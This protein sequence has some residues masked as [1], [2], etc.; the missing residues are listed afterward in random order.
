MAGGARVTRT[1]PSLKGARPLFKGHY[2]PRRPLGGKFLPPGRWRSHAVAGLVGIGAWHLRFLL[3][4]LL[5]Q[6]QTALGKTGGIAPLGSFT[7][8]S[9]LLCLGQWAWD[10]NGVSPGSGGFAGAAIR[11]GPGA[12]TSFFLRWSHFFE[13]PRYIK[14][15][16]KPVFLILD[17]KP[18]PRSPA[19]Y[20]E[21]WN[22]FAVK[23]GFPGIV[24]IRMLSHRSLDSEIASLQ[25]Q[26]VP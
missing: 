23:R 16:K 21:S 3:P 19:G 7:Q 14:I 2:Q 6:R 22:A 12:A 26:I 15:D 20:L 13:D 9:L 11:A 17:F 18:Y 5:V 1:G 4:A 24:F 10:T 25:R 8:A